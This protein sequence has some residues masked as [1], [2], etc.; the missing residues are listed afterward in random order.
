M[1]DS[2]MPNT[3]TDDSALR[4]LIL[5][6]VSQDSSGVGRSVN[7]QVDAGK[8]WVKREGWDLK[9][10]IRETG[11]AS[12]YSTRRQRTEWLE[13]LSWIASGEIDA[14]L[15]WENS[16]ATRDLAGYT[17]L[18][19]ACAKNNVKWGYGG[20]LYDLTQRS[21]RFRTGLDALLAE[22][23]ADRTS[24]RVIRAHSANARAGRPHGKAIF[25]Y[26]RIYDS[27]T[28]ALLRVEVDPAEAALVREAAQRY[29]DGETLYSIAQDWNDRGIPTRRPQRKHHRGGAAWRGE[30]IKQMLEMPAYAGLRQYRGEVIGEA[31]WDPIIASEAWYKLQA[32]LHAPERQR[33]D[34]WKIRYLLTGVAR[35][36]HG[37]CVGNVRV[38]RNSSK[39][40]AGLTHYQ[41][42]ICEY[43]PHCSMNMKFLDAI[44]TEFVLERICRPDFLESLHSVGD[45]QSDERRELLR[46]IAEHRAWLDSVRE[47]AARERNLE[48][49]FD[50]E[51][52]VKP[53]IDEATKKLSR[54]STMSP[55]VT[56]LAQAPDVRDAWEDLT[57]TSKREVIRSLLEVQIFP[58]TR[59]GAKGLQQAIDR[60]RITWK[61]TL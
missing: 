21:D 42:Y 50:Q 55:Q 39:T 10:V 59:R 25:G 6:R 45:D 41:N 28:K 7:E 24:E 37:G 54:L 16:R 14:L 1:L 32:L 44:V 3:V 51:R 53:L 38:S 47:R 26:R 30:T 31:M 57:I 60:T 52:R 4:V 48:L 8:E 27:Q 11:S 49:L 15:T 2:A 20:T 19:Q 35:C 36:G 22:D 17:E 9:K 12:R 34:G 61:H 56:A 43:G 46:I 58:A 33:T 18:R 13:A 23:E 40:A 5:A 29:L